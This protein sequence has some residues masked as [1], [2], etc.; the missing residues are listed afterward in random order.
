[1]SFCRRI[2]FAQKVVSTFWFDALADAAPFPQFGG[3]RPF[4]TGS[5]APVLL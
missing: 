2:K 4:C 3:C 5:G 1:M